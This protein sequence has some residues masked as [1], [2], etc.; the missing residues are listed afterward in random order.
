MVFTLVKIYFWLNLFVVNMNF[1]PDAL[2]QYFCESGSAE[3]DKSRWAIPHIHIWMLCSPL[4]IIIMHPSKI[5]KQFVIAIVNHFWRS[6]FGMLLLEVLPE[7]A[8]LP[9]WHEQKHL[10]LH[11]R[12][13]CLS[14]ICQCH[15]QRNKPGSVNIAW[16]QQLFGVLTMCQSTFLFSN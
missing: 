4:I 6:C 13:P 8:P 14:P 10:M 16:L 5:G 7:K 12:T 15:L 11:V 9:L 1:V 2:L 3:V